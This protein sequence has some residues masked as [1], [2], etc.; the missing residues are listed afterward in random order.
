MTPLRSRLAHLLAAYGI[1]ISL[2]SLA[3]CGG[4]S[5]GVVTTPTPPPTAP[6]GPSITLLAP[7][8]IM[9]GVGLGIANVYGANFTSDAQVY[10]DGAAIQT[11]PGSAGTLEWTLPA[12]PGPT[13]GVHQVAVHQSS[14]SLTA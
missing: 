1:V 4:V 10:F 14:G 5:G 13:T 11:F 12:A 9:A 3:A 8:K 7:S 2:I 6:L